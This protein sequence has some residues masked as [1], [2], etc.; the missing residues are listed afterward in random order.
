MS[1]LA[2]AEVIH[3]GGLDA[4]YQR[5][6]DDAAEREEAIEAEYLRLI[7]QPVSELLMDDEI[8]SA[9]WAAAERRVDQSAQ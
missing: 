3:Y 9:L 2:R 5:Y 8:D 4:S 7:E 1:A 6:L